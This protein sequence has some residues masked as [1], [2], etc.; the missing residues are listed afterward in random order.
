M[1]VC[2]VIFLCYMQLFQ[3]YSACSVHRWPSLLSNNLLGHCICT[4]II[5]AY[6]IMCS[7]ELYVP[8]IHV[9]GRKQI[10]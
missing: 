7:Q 3:I 5:L 2:S 9:A 1:I 10:R 4:T 6:K 8:D